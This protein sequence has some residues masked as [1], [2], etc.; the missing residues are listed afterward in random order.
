M[1]IDVLAVCTGNIC[2]SPAVER[3]LAARTGLVVRSAGTRAAVGSPVSPAMALL[4][5]DGGI[6]TEGFA[7][8]QLTAEHVRSAR[9]V[10][11]C[12][13]AHR[14]TVLEI[15]PGALAQTFTLRELA[16][17][18]GYLPAARTEQVRATASPRARVRELAAA[19]HELRTAATLPPSLPAADDIADPIGRPPAIYAEV[20][21]QI[22]AA[23]A[24][25]ARLLG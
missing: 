16:R 20:Y 7:A 13:S 17:L 10:V 5:S 6:A 4:L 18:I 22:N 21:T 12:T 3:L 23:V 1:K 2:R 15:E 19:A 24:A 11:T 9:L 8:R 25:L 14:D